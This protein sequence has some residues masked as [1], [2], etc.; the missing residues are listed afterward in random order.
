MS[1]RLFLLAITALKVLRAFHLC[2]VN[3]QRERFSR[4]DSSLPRRPR[5]SQKRGVLRVESAPRTDSAP[6]AALADSTTLA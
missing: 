5:F 3:V 4:R 2:V 1:L 6:L